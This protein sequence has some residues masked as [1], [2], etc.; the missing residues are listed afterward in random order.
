[1]IKIAQN[2]NPK[3]KRCLRPRRRLTGRG[4]GTPGVG[5]S[6]GTD[7]LA[8]RE[9]DCPDRVGGTFSAEVGV[10]LATLGV[11]V[12]PEVGRTTGRLGS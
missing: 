8:A 1:M 2:C 4:E 3:P 5:N 11:S 9:N 7:A 12:P 6:S 10:A